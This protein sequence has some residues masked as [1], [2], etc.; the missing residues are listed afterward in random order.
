MTV[1]SSDRTTSTEQHRLHKP[2]VGGSSPP[3]AI[4]SFDELI[5]SYHSDRE[6][7]SK[8]QL[9][10]LQSQGP[11]AFHSRYGRASPPPLLRAHS[12]ADPCT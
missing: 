12:P 5:T 9:W 4:L 6:W 11:A 3:A 8:S 7:W 1:A 2:G 10:T